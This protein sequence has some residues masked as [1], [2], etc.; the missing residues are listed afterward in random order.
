F[1][2]VL[3]Y[4]F[5]AYIFVTVLPPLLGLQGAAIAISMVQVAQSVLLYLGIPFIAGI[6]TRVI[7]L[8][9]K[10]N[11]WYEKYFLPAISPLTLIALLFTIVVMFALQGERI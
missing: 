5:Y 9:T 11:E 1:F 10:G 3:F 6:L 2:Q 7:L 8:R 4:S